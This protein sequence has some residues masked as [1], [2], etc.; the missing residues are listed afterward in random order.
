MNARVRD[1]QICKDFREIQ[2]NLNVVLKLEWNCVAQWKV[3][4]SVVHAN[5]TLKFSKSL[6]IGVMNY[7]SHSSLFFDLERT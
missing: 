5:F 1:T 6:Q 2:V 4:E 7:C 3:Q